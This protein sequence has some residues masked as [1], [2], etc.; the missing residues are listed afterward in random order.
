M[1]FER[2][3]NKKKKIKEEGPKSIDFLI[4]KMLGTFR[5]ETNFI[6]EY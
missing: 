6:D 4:K 1:K 2:K 3:K 5:H